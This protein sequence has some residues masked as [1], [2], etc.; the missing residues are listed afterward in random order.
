MAN[1]VEQSPSSLDHPERWLP[2]LRRVLDQQ[3]ALYTELD[4]LSRLQASLIESG[5]T[6]QLLTLLTSRQ[7][8]IDQI[9]SLN[10]DLDPFVRSWAGLLAQVSPEHRSELEQR[11]ASLDSLIG[12]IARR[13]DDDRRMLDTRRRA[14]SDGIGSAARA[15][16]ATSAYGADLSGRTATI[17]RYQ[18]REA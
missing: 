7:V 17:P 11:V 1:L 15:R 4:G 5:E 12:G 8:L 3:H 18:D 2:R 14:A 16:A 9:A 13:D 10:A 6:S